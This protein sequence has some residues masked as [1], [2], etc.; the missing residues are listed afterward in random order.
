MPLRSLKAPEVV[1]VGDQVL[2]ISVTSGVFFASGS[3]LASL[4]SASPQRLL[5]DGE[6]AAGGRV[7][8]VLQVLAQLIGGV[9]THDPERDVLVL[10]AFGVE[11][12]GVVRST[13]G[14]RRRRSR[15]APVPSAEERERLRASSSWCLPFVSSLG[16]RVGR[17]THPGGTGVPGVARTVRPVAPG[18]TSG[19]MAL[20][21]DTPSCPD[22]TMTAAPRRTMSWPCSVIRTRTPSSTDWRECPRAEGLD[23]RFREGVRREVQA[24]RRARSPRHRARRRRGRARCRAAPPRRGGSPRALRNRMPRASRDDSEG[25]DSQASRHPTLPHAHCG[26]PSVPTVTCPISPAAKRLPRMGWPAS[27]SPE[28]TPRP[29][30]TSST[31][32]GAP[33]NVYSASTAALASLATRTGTPEGAAQRPLE[34][35]ARPAEVAAP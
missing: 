10:G 21:Q 20:R 32:S 11:P 3:W 16:V 26:P 19:A 15:R 2:P 7:V 18:G 33:P 31:S 17:V 25:T 28:P 30:L 13:G 23:G 27:S 4:V 35:E 12:R 34:I 1:K 6:G 8:L 9:A 5:L 14:G 29:T 24:G 22:R